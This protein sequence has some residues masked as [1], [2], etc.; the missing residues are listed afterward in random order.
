M[1]KLL[2]LTL[3]LFAGTSMTKT[4][5]KAAHPVDRIFVDRWSPRAMSGD[6]VSHEEM[7]TL[8]EAARWA[9]SSFNGQ[10]WRF[11]Y[12][13]K[14]EKGWDKLFGSL[15][16]FNQAWVKNAGALILIVSKTTFDHNN[17]PSR[18]HSFDAGAAWA[19]LALQGSVMDLVIHG[20]SGMD[21][22]TARKAFNIPQD[23]EI[24]AMVAVGKPAEPIALPEAM[25]A[26][27]KPSDRKAIAEFAFNGEFRK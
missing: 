4:T 27:E 16:E 10:P 12:A 21:Y 2:L 20:M 7:M 8:F 22:D 19:N 13:H 17:Q 15:V 26:M 9:P 3:I 25:R 14:G 6:A 11:I 1:K 18:T 5:R 23:Y 24:E